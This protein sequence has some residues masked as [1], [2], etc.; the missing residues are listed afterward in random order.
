M[1]IGH[2]NSRK[3]LAPIAAI[4]ALAATAANVQAQTGSP[5]PPQ[6]REAPEGNEKECIAIA[7]PHGTITV[8]RG[9]RRIE[10]TLIGGACEPLGSGISALFAIYPAA[11]NSPLDVVSSRDCPSYQAKIDELWSAKPRHVRSRSAPAKVQVGPF[12]IVDTDDLFELKSSRGKRAAQIWLREMLMAVR[13]CW[14]TIRDDQTRSVVDDLY[15][16][17]SIIFPKVPKVQS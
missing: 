11:D 14:N 13:P 7:V 6:G 5:S 4:C 9:E 16:R 12:A 3:I 10:I 17:L 1:A 2:K 8:G 15:K